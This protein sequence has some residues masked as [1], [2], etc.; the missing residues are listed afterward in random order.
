MP[1]DETAPD[2]PCSTYDRHKLECETI[3]RGATARGA[4]RGCSLR[5]SNVYGYGGT[6]VNDNR[7]IL[8]AMM[9]RAID[10]EPLT[11]YGDGGY[12]RDFT[13]LDDVVD[14]F[15]LVISEPRVNDGRHYV[16]AA[17]RGHT[18]A[19][20]YAFIAEAALAHTGRRVEIH[21]VPEPHNLQPIERRNFVGNSRLFQER[22]G[23]RP[24]FDLKAGI[25]DYFARARSHPAAV[26][27]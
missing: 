23:W 26:V 1:V 6:S 3:L 19:E 2:R 8:N 10:G 18:L 12:I 9:R 16:I 14:A 15:R 5:L 20:S 24:R 7:G 11:L 25:R 21:H 27:G 17:G 13:H 22:T 4:V